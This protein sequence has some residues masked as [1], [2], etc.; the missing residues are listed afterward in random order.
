MWLIRAPRPAK[1]HEEDPVSAKTCGRAPSLRV[2]RY[3]RWYRHWRV[4]DAITLSLSGPA[5]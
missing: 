1:D 3:D 5:P 4:R 2:L